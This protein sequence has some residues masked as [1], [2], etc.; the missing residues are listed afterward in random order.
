MERPRSFSSFQ[1]IGIDACQRLDQGRLTVI[2][3]SGGPDDDL[4]H[5][6]SHYSIGPRE[7]LDLRPRRCY[8]RGG[9]GCPLDAARSERPLGS[10]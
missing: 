3:M 1:A 9:R 4:F 10:R 7:L 6:N 8:T 5:G 2:H